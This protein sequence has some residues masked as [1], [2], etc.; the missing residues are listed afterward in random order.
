MGRVRE[1]E[2]KV[3]TQDRKNNTKNKYVCKE[4]KVDRKAGNKEKRQR[5]RKETQDGQKN[6]M[7]EE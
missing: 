3:S 7:R 6:E 2:E 1:Q 5:S 4:R